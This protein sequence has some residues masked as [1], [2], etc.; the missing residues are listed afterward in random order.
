VQHQILIPLSVYLVCLVA[1]MGDFFSIK[2]VMEDK[3]HGYVAA[4]DG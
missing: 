4:Y 2:T 1:V 3:L